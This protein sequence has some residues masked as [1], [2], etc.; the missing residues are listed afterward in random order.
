ML[1]NFYTIL[2]LILFCIIVI[3]IVGDKLVQYAEEL[4]ILTNISG[5]F[6]GLLLI[7]TITSIPELISTVVSAKKGLYGLASGGILGSNIVNLAILSLICLI[8]YKK[9]SYITKQSLFSLLISMLILCV[10]AFAIVLS[11]IK[12]IEINKYFLFLIGGGIYVYAMFY[13][14][15]LHQNAH[16]E[17]QTDIIKPVTT[18]K[19]LPKVIFRFMIFS[20]LIIT[21]SW[22]LV[23]L[24]DNLSL[25]PAPIIGKPLGQHFIGTLILAFVTSVPEFVTTFQIVRNGNT[26]IALENI[27]G[28]NMFNLVALLFASTIVKGNFWKEINIDNLFIV[29]AIFASTILI[30]ILALTK[31]NSTQISAVIYVSV[32]ALWIYSL[33]MIF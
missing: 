22:F 16:T 25:I 18:T 11:S 17:S 12:G 3:F 5:A 30:S 33:Q 27:S 1:S 15:Y 31:K 4:S 20:F 6:I 24:C 23:I 28:S 21:I 29:F 32:L 19:T 8:H 9:H 10:P 2:L 13:N 26:S 7:A 14:Y